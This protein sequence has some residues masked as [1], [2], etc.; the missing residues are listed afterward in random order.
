MKQALETFGRY[1]VGEQL[2]KGGLSTV[3]LAE[4]K[5]KDGR[6]RK[7]ALKRLLPEAAAK[8][9]LRAQFV[10][11]ASLLRYLKHPNIA[12]TY[13]A[14]NVREVFFIAMEYV[15]G[16][17]LKDLMQHV[18]ATI[19][20]MP[21]PIALGI[22]AEICDALDHAHNSCDEQGKQLHIVHRDV[23]PQNIIVSDTGVAKLIDFGL[24]KAK[25]GTGSSTKTGQGVIKGKFNYLAPEYLAGKL[26]ARCDIWALGVVMYEILTSRRLFDAPDVFDLMTRIKK[27]PIPRPSLANPRV[28]HDL[29]EIVMTA[30]ERNPNHRW[31][32]AAM[33]RDAIRGVIAQPGNFV[34][35][36]HV[37]DWMRWL[38]TQKPGTEASGVSELV[39]MTQPKRPPPIPQR[40]TTPTDELAPLKWL[41]K[42]LP[43]GQGKR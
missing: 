39:K 19:G 14:G 22:A 23:S 18:A 17:T 16:P 15:A 40:A 43:R 12:A 4:E 7:V 33:M 20:N 36:R 13:S 25:V 21:T 1:T 6:V 31:Q 27:F 29:D 37:S 28:T 9:E 26:D 11:E 2:G 5:T 8:K 30:L 42:I 35:H 32:T 34:D 3:H 38:F 41:R 24:A 10:H